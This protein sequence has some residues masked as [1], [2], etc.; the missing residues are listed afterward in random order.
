[1]SPGRRRGVMQER[2]F[3]LEYEY[4]LAYLP[5]AG[6]AALGSDAASRL[7]VKVANERLRLAGE[8]QNNFW[9]NGGKLYFDVGHVEWATPE[10]RSVRE[11]IVYDKAGE[12]LLSSVAS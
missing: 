11:A 7:A 3:G 9:H 12:R 8:P 6:G 5:A 2:V 10:C 1:M 4:G